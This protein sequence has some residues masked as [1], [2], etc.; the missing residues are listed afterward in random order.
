MRSYKIVLIEK[1]TAKEDFFYKI[2]KHTVTGKYKKQNGEIKMHKRSQ[3]TT[4]KWKTVFH[5]MGSEQLFNNKNSLWHEIKDFCK[6]MI[7]IN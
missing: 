3:F 7:L 5:F 4:H 1:M 2:K 6:I